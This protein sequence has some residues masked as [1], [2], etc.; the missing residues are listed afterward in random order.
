MRVRVTATNA[1]GSGSAQSAQSDHGC[2]GD[3]ERAHRGTTDRPMISGTPRGR[4]DA[5]SR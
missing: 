5:D 3:L 2:Q 4:P 1:E